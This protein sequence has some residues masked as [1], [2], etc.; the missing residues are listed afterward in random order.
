L[1]LVGAIACLAIVKLVGHYAFA[2]SVRRCQALDFKFDGLSDMNTTD[3]YPG[4]AQ[5]FRLHLEL[6]I[7]LKKLIAVFAVRV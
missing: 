6:S 7:K 4:A 1:V 2:A 5:K 3:Q